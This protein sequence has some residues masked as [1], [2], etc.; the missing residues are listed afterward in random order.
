MAKSVAYLI[1]ILIGA[2]IF[3]SNNGDDFLH[4]VA[5]TGGLYTALQCC[6]FF[7]VE[8]TERKMK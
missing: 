3:C 6:C 1:C 2:F 4:I 8:E 7:I 5:R